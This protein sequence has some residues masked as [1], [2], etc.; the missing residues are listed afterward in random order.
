MSW[1]SPLGSHDS[2]TA[3]AAVTWTASGRRTK[4]LLFNL[5]IFRNKKHTIQLSIGDGHVDCGQIMT[6]H[7]E[8]SGKQDVRM[9]SV[10]ASDESWCS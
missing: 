4:S 1:P 3:L 9:L 10:R 2:A 6:R 8:K 5:C 7:G